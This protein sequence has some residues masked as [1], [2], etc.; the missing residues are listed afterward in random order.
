[1]VSIITKFADLE[2]SNV[3]W[4]AKLLRRNPLRAALNIDKVGFNASALAR[5]S[6]LTSCQGK[7]KLLLVTNLR[8]DV[9]I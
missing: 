5:L 3:K 8:V 7:G 4:H 2:Q 1:M 9:T 6:Q